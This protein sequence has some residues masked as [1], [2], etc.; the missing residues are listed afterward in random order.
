MN[1]VSAKAGFLKSRHGIVAHDRIAGSRTCLPCPARRRAG[2]AAPAPSLQTI[3]PYAPFVQPVVPPCGQR[4][5]RQIP[6]FPKAP[7]DNRWDF[8]VSDMQHHQ[9]RGSL[10]ELL[11]KPL[12]GKLLPEYK[13]SELF[14]TRI[15][16]QMLFLGLPQERHIVEIQQRHYVCLHHPT[17]NIPRTSAARKLPG[18][19]MRLE[20]QGVAK[21][22]RGPALS[23]YVCAPSAWLTNMLRMVS[24]RGPLTIQ[25]RT[26][27]QVP[28]RVRRP[29]R[30]PYL[31]VTS[32]IVP[33]RKKSP[34]TVC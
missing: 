7:S 24:N 15:S 16:N 34:I 33:R 5:T 3:D 20:R 10:T 18:P 31:R 27:C 32:S 9:V 17:I 19:L 25:R 22:R 30:T 13:F 26:T 6:P 29:N 23:S 28:H 8:L 21:F 4:L 2:A 14:S 11:L 1:K 12:C